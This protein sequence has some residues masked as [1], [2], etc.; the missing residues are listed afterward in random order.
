MNVS[1]V[2]PTLNEQENII[3]CLRRL[4]DQVGA[5][6]EVII[7]DGGSTDKTIEVCKRAGCK[8]YELKGSSIGLARHAGVTEA[9]NEIIVSA[10][11]DSLPPN[12]WLDRIKNHFEKNED[13]SVLWGTIKD[14]NGVPIRNLIGKFSTIFRGASGNNT[15]YRKSSYE[16]LKKGYPD[17]S[18]AEDWVIIN[19]L[20]TVGEAVRDKKLV[21]VMNMDRKRYQTI[22]IVASGGAIAALGH[23][24]NTAYS[25]MVRAGGLGL[26]GTE[27]V[28][29]GASNTPF[30]HDQ[31]GMGLALAGRRFE[32]PFMTGI[33]AGIV[34]HHIAT[35]GLSMAPTELQ[36]NTNRV[37]G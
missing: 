9:T 3:N 18:F 29:E 15:A 30:H 33:G 25:D 36:Q 37:I 2:I 8:T 5:R 26:A 11:A 19:K 17:I 7:I 6:D 16:K 34:G 10:D 14:R 24:T 23:F 32:S 4:K 35:E 22:P 27:L 13:L 12:G 31:V 1:I 28:Y 20:A 21:M